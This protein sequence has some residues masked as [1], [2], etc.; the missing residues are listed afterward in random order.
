MCVS[1]ELPSGFV[2]AA[3]PGSLSF[4]EKMANNASARDATQESGPLRVDRE[5]ETL[6]RKTLVKLREAI[7]SGYFKPDHRLVERDICEQ[8]GV[9]RSSVREALRYLE[10]EGLVES[11]GAKGIFVVNLSAAEAL[12]IYEL[13]IAVEA[14][15][16]EHF[17]ARA[18]DDEIDRLKQIFARVKA[19]AHTDPEEYWRQ[20]DLFF[21]IMM[22]GAR[23]TIAY[24]LM[25]SLRT[26]IR[27]L[28]ATTTRLA[29]PD[30]RDGTVRH[31]AALKDALAARD[32]DAAAQACRAFVAR[33]ARFASECLKLRDS[34]QDT[35][36]LPAG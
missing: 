6:R 23:N 11:R 9:S 8:T 22:R 18:T 26:R 34:G 32:G 3:E 24:D 27:Y 19:M 31:L 20:S 25:L 36:Q 13:R 14:A 35:G 29:T 10:S 1:A 16:A 5:T 15:A 17:A 7:V 12:E 28:R 21:D 2:P 33:S 30:Y 4:R